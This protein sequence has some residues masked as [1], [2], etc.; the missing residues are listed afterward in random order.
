MFIILLP[1]A[2]M[3]AGGFEG[4]HAKLPDTA[5]SLTHIGVGTIFTYFFL[6]VFTMVIGQDLW[7][8]VFTARSDRV[9]K[10]A[11]TAAAFYGICY[12]M[13]GA[14]IGMSAKVLLPEIA[15]RNAVY[16]EIVR[17]V[18]PAGIAGLVVAGALSAIMSTSS[19][20]LIATA[21][22]AKE[23]IMNVIRRNRG[24]TTTHSEGDEVRSSRWYILVF[25]VLM[26]GVAC[27]LQDVIAGLTIAGA[28]L[29]GGLLVAIIGGMI[30]Q[31]G[32]LRGAVVSIVSG[33]VLT[34]G[35][36]IVMKDIYANMPIFIGLGGSLLSYLVVSLLDKPTPAHILR[37]WNSRS[38][39]EEVPAAAVLDSDGKD[40]AYRTTA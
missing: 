4:L 8:R 2:L 35:S 1:V 16:T 6:Y 34:L 17:N 28:I 32:T 20:A 21:T 10:W 22:V 13:A 38:S 37:E 24:D 15:D 12:A 25:G 33:T 36:M 3:R 19:G 18:L 29:V 31:R 27:I 9:A 14:F 26:I 30:W 11:G 23:D 7:Q 40:A 5:F 39:G